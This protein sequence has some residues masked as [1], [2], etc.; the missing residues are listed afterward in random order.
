MNRFEAL[1]I[2]I[3]LFLSILMLPRR[4]FGGLL[5][6]AVSTTIAISVVLAVVSYWG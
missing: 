3:G 5:W 6:L 1:A 4:V 2:T